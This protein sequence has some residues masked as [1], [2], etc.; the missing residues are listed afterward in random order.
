MTRPTKYHITKQK[1]QI[2]LKEL[3]NTAVQINPMDMKK[4][5]IFKLFVTYA[6]PQ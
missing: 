2:K 3:R 6:H 4:G 5:D 1:E